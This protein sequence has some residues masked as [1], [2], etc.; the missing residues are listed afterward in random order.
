VG[1]G[2]QGCKVDLVGGRVWGARVGGLKCVV[3]KCVGYEVSDLGFEVYGG[4]C[5]VFGL[6]LRV[7]GLGLG[8]AVSL[9]HPT[10]C[11]APV[12]DLLF[13]FAFGTNTSPHLLPFCRA[14][15]VGPPAPVSFLPAS[16]RAKGFQTT[17]TSN[18]GPEIFHPK[19]LKTLKND[20]LC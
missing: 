5:T 4:E 3:L 1:D 17:K 2:V 9:N 11:T 10:T 12:R 7:E 14:S 6:G 20:C 16:V 18:K 13:V 8:G 19:T 15:N